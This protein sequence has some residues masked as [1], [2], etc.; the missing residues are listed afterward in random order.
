MFFLGKGVEGNGGAS[1]LSSS[2]KPSLFLPPLSYPTSKKA[3]SVLL[4][5]F[6]WAAG[7]KCLGEPPVLAGWCSHPFPAP[8]PPWRGFLLFACLLPP[9]CKEAHHGHF[10]D[11]GES[12]HPGFV[13]WGRM[14]S[15]FCH[16]LMILP[17]PCSRAGG[18]PVTFSISKPEA[19]AGQAPQPP[20]SP[21]RLVKLL[22]VQGLPPQESACFGKKHKNLSSLCS[23]PLFKAH[24]VERAGT[25]WRAAWA[26]W[27]VWCDAGGFFFIIFLSFGNIAMVTWGKRL[28]SISLTS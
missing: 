20:S 19:M 25:A 6:H 15:P 5:Q 9:S 17:I 1:Q 4:G 28:A 11:Y 13:V 8:T 10:F 21:Q 2:S 23:Q 14:K 27:E 22:G 16:H 12:V 3:L 18:E 26:S 7:Q 24:P